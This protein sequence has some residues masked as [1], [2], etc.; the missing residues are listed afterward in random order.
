MSTPLERRLFIKKMGVLTSATTVAIALPT[1]VAAV[2]T[3]P[4]Q[5]IKSKGYHVTDHIRAYYDTLVK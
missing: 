4:S 5:V 2:T 1:A 3:E